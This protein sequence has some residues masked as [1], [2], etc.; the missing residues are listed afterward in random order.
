[1]RRRH[2]ITARNPPGSTCRCWGGSPTT[3]CPQR[4]NLVLSSPRAP[5]RGTNVTLSTQTLAGRRQTHDGRGGS[6]AGTDETIL[7]QV[8]A[9]GSRRTITTSEFAGL[10]KGTRIMHENLLTDWTCSLLLIRKGIR[11]PHALRHHYPHTDALHVV[12]AHI[13]SRA[14]T[15]AATRIIYKVKAHIGNSGNEM[16]DKGRSNS[17]ATETSPPRYTPLTVCY[18][19]RAVST[20]GHKRDITREL[21]GT[22]QPIH[23]ATH[24]RHYPCEE[25]SGSE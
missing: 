20:R 24:A 18:T 14:E 5:S 2:P 15:I 1:M 17:V 11:H 10:S 16:A 12:I 25:L 4:R 9:D 3:R 6:T 22:D 8:D 23:R 7:I 19:P 21:R 13:R